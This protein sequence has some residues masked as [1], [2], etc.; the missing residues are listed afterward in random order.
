MKKVIGKAERPAK[1]V[2]IPLLF[3]NCEIEVST[4]HRNILGPKSTRGSSAKSLSRPSEPKSTS[5]RKE[6]LSKGD[7][8]K[9][10]KIDLKKN[11]EKTVIKAMVKAAGCKSQSHIK[12]KASLPVP[13]VPAKEN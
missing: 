4:P 7:G 12:T 11:S 10:I 9:V 5:N 3:K 13:V 6:F 1:V 8:K 2:N